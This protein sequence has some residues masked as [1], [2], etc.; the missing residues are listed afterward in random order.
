MRANEDNA[1]AAELRRLG[2][3]YEGMRD[4]IKSIVE[5]VK[6]IQPMLAEIPGIKNEVEVMSDDVKAI[7]AAIKDTNRDLHL[8]ETRVDRLEAAI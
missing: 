5:A 1:T 7:K 2:V 8:L 6:T 3:L 4:D